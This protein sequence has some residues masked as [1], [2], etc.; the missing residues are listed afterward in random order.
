LKRAN[1]AHTT[2]AVVVALTLVCTTL[3]HLAAPLRSAAQTRPGACIDRLQPA[4]LRARIDLIQGILDEQTFG[5]RLWWH[6][7]T[8]TL[9]GLGAGQT[10]AAVL[11]DP[12][13][14]KIANV[15]GATGSFLG[16]LALMIRQIPTANAARE[17][18][19]M[20]DDTTE[21]LQRKL[22]NG[23]KVLADAAKVEARGRG[24]SRQLPLLGWLGVTAAIMGARYGEWKQWGV[25]AVGSTFFYE[26][27]TLT[28]PT[29]AIP[30]WEAYAWSS[31]ACMVPYLRDQPDDGPE[32]SVVP[33]GGGIALRVT[34]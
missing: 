8:V 33:G 12:K 30:A 34:F 7:W 15:I 32:V 29:A 2:R 18:R 26:L 25:H 3:V 11:F 13:G 14:D 17:L 16:V 4:E 19:Q 21:D 10:A 24:L 6:G 22:Y 20:P 31:Q 1:A 5:S 27:R 9:L 23:E 28:Q